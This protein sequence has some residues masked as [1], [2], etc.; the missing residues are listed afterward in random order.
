MDLIRYAQYINFIGI[1]DI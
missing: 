1:A